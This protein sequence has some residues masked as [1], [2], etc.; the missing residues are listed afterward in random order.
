MTIALTISTLAAIATPV[1]AA[2]VTTPDNE[3]L[4]HINN[5]LNG[6]TQAEAL[7]FVEG[8]LAPSA[9]A[10]TMWKIYFK[11]DGMYIID[12]AATETLVAP[13]TSNLVAQVCNTRL[14]LT[15]AT[16]VTTSDVT[17]ATNVYITPYGGERIAL[18][19][20]SGTWVMYSFSEITLSLSGLAADKNYDV[21]MYDSAGTVVAEAV[22]WTNDTTRATA[23][24]V[25]D[26]VYVKSGTTTKR[27][28]GTFRTTTTIGQCEDSLTKRYV[29]NY[30][31][32][33]IREIEVK[34]TTNSW[35][36]ATATMRPWN[37]STAN[38]VSFV[39]G[40]AE[41]VV[42]L[43]FYGYVVASATTSFPT[44]AI[45]LDSTSTP[46]GIFIPGTASSTAGGTAMA[47]YSANVAAGFHYLQLL[48][49]VASSTTFYGDNGVTTMQ[50]GANGFLAA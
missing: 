6:A 47:S 36:Y 10:S 31:N 26:G 5:I 35:T 40:V 20:G 37:N 15:S 34:E 13:T 4:A 16:P 24:A 2:D 30:Y 19:D 8:A 39:R 25:Q 50:N 48:E 3:N 33:V 38:R 42:N 32:R 28:V 18:Y 29:W 23:L 44:V 1:N 43:D 27:Y 9:P 41:N 45:G 46:S 12:D 21:F 7:L 14:T 22:V 11:P 49:Y 17:A